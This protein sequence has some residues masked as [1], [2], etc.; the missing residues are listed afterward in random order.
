M[1]TFMSAMSWAQWSSVEVQSLSICFEIRY[2]ETKTTEHE[3]FERK[4]CT[5][6][7]IIVVDQLCRLIFLFNAVFYVRFLCE[8]FKGMKTESDWVFSFHRCV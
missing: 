1:G 6:N 7:L 5:H 8:N 3:S 4:I 2:F